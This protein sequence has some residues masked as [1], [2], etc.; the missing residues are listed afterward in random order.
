[1]ALGVGRPLPPSKLLAL[2]RR[3]AGSMDANDMEYTYLGDTGLEVSR[4]CLGTMNFGEW[5]IDDHGRCVEVIDR[6]VDM[7]IN[8]VDITRTLRVL[9]SCRT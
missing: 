5:G 7:G 6:A 9:V 4:L 2:R 8:F 1:V 3:N